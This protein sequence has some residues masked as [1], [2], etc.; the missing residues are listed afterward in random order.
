MLW[1]EFLPTDDEADEMK[2]S[3]TG[4]RNERA[5]H[6][7]LFLEFPVRFVLSITD[8]MGNDERKDMPHDDQKQSFA[9]LV[10]SL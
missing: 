8:D 9:R 1:F 5:N 6:L 3:I 4:T 10:S 7:A 2:E